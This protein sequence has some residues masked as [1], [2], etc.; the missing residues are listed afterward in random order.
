MSPVNVLTSD[1]ISASINRDG[2]EVGSNEKP[3]TSHSSLES[4]ILVQLPLNPV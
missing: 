1:E 3:K 4:Q 2:L